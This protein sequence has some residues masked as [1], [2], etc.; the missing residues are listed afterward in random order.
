LRPS[1]GAELPA[2]VDLDVTTELA[3]ELWARAYCR[4]GASRFCPTGGSRAGCPGRADCGT[5]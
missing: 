2:A 3:T 1:V 4:R 5:R